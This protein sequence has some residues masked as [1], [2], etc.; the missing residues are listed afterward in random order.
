[1]N[2]YIKYK[3]ALEVK[4]QNIEQMGSDSYIFFTL[5]QVATIARVA[6]NHLIKRGSMVKLNI[7]MSKAYYFNPETEENL[8]HPTKEDIETLQN[9]LETLDDLVPQYSQ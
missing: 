5:N 1:M 4:I 8:I 7:D 2:R 3:N 6:P 9:K